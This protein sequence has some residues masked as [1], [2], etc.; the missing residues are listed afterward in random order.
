MTPVSY[1]PPT[2]YADRLCERGRLYMRRFFVGDDPTFRMEVDAYRDKLRAQLKAKRKDE[3]DDGKDGK[4]GK[5]QMRKRMDED[6]VKKDVE[7]W[8]F[9]KAKEEF[10]RHGD[11]GGGGDV[12]YG[13][14]WGRELGKTMFWM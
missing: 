8:V 14:P 10:N 3:V 9:G 2:Y 6:T 5:E 7:K 4:I 13:N 12:G 11:G 1:V